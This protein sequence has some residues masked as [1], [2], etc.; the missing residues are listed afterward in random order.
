M[1]KSEIQMKKIHKKTVYRIFTTILLSAV[2]VFAIAVTFLHEYF[3]SKSTEYIE[4]YPKHSL[5]IKERN[6]NLNDILN[7]LENKSISSEEYIIEFNRIKE[8]SNSKI[9]EYKS[10]LKDIRKSNSYLGYSSFKNFM[11]GIGFPISGFIL[12]LLLLSV[13]IKNIPN[14]FKRTFYTLISF[15]FSI[16]W[17]Y[18]VVWSFLD[19][20]NSKGHYDFEPWVYD[21]MLYVLPVIVFFA[22]YFL[23]KHHITIEQKLTKVIRS[24]SRFMVKDA[25]KHVKPE[26]MTDYKK[27]YVNA[28]KDGMS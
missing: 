15:T 19:R 13:V 5:I 11:L 27:D 28:L 1:K 26:S 2:I 14:G 8:T 4:H 25:K 12:T 17:G 10:Q 3:P 22:A 18:W 9:K 6:S 7:K 20:V 23:F 24:M 16:C 21:F